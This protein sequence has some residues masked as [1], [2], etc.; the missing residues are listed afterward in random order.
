VA[1]R[2]P[3]VDG[4]DFIGQAVAG[5]AAA[6]VCQDRP[7]GLDVGWA[8]VA[9][10]AE[11]LGRLAQA[12]AG[13]PARSL[14]LVGVTGTK[15]KTTFTH[16]ARHVLSRAGGRVGVIGTI[17][18]EWPGQ[19]LPA[20]NTT[21]GPV[22]LAEMLALMAADAV[23][24][25]VMEVSSH[26]LHQRRVAGLEFDA[27][28]F[29]NLSGDHLDYHRTMEAYL[30][31]KA[32]LFESL[33]PEAV[34]AINV[35]DPAGR[36]VAKRSGGRVLGFGLG[37]SA[38]LRGEI[39][40]MSADRTRFVMT[41][42]PASEDVTTNLLGRHNVMNS[43]AAA[44]TCAGLG[45]DLATIAAALREPINVPGRLQRVGGDGFEVL[46]DYAHTDD[47]LD[48][49]LSALRPLAGRHKLVVVFG[50]GGDRD[51]SKRPRMAAAAEQWAD[52]IVVTSDNPRTESP[53]AIIDEVMAGFGPQTRAEVVRE[54]DRRSAIERAIRLAE[55]G[56][57]VVIAGKGHE[58]YQVLGARRVHFD[59]REVA[60]E[61]LAGILIS[62]RSKR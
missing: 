51:A 15:G 60:A 59:D 20:P 10:S 3:V 55:P 34:A 16:L 35:D 52:R 28:A 56:D 43:L 13:W 45:V 36:I 47:A 19:S 50:C 57:V 49:V 44:A 41:L 39:R 1:V 21:P 46:V 24:T 6:V 4:H 32:L 30:D 58:D 5:G 27:A 37:V 40:E 31:A 9:D 18:Y 25:A 61:A 54:C 26:A 29:M 2:G 38:E 11:A 42:G 12:A 22:Q 33:A 23:D 8:Q 62:G 7:A 17:R 14:R 53:E 48:N